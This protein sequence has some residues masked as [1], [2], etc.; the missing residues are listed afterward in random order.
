MVS[1]IAQTLV[2]TGLLEREPGGWYR[3]GLHAFEIG[4]QYQLHRVLEEAASSW[5]CPVMRSSNP[6]FGT[7]GIARA[8]STYIVRTQG[9]QHPEARPRWPST[10]AG[11][12]RWAAPKELQSFPKIDSRKLRKFRNDAT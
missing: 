11:S 7:V 1:R 4:S 2:S 12:F 9:R 6:I 10:V 5:A 8:G 3:I